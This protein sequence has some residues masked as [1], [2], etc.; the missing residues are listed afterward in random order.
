MAK[1]GADPWMTATRIS[2]GLA[3]MQFSPNL[4]FNGGFGEDS[5]R[6]LICERAFGQSLFDAQGEY[7][8]KG[9]SGLTFTVPPWDLFRDQRSHHGTD[10]HVVQHPNHSTQRGHTANCAHHL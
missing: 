9:L 5:S 2:M 4:R 6:F 3:K 1:Q 8:D 7:R 10:Q